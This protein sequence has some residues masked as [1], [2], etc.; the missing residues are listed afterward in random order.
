[1]SFTVEQTKK[2]GWLSNRLVVR[3]LSDCTIDKRSLHTGW[4]G[5]PEVR[6]RTAIIRA[7]ETI[8]LKIP[9][10]RVPELRSTVSA[11]QVAEFVDQ[12]LSWLEVAPDR[13]TPSL[14]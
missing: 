12:P 3:A 14:P 9:K 5:L 11:E 6:K 2:L 1:V 10:N 7:G 13:V 8:E 4:D